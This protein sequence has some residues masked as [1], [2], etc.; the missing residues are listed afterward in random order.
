MKEE[1]LKNVPYYGVDANK[2][3]EKCLGFLA[4]V[5][6]ISTKERERLNYELEKVKEWGIAKVFLFAKELC[7]FSSATTIVSE[8]NSYINYLLEVVEV[9]ACAYDLPFERLYNEYRPYLPTFNLYVTKGRKGEIL[10]KLYEKYG[11]STI[12][13]AEDNKD[14]YYV[15]SKS[16][17]AKFIKESV[18][19]AKE[20]EED[21]E[22]II[23]CLTCREL[24]MLGYYNFSI[25]EVEDISYSLEEKFTEDIIYEKAKELF[26]YKIP[27]TPSFTEIEEIK[28]ILKDTENKLIYQEQVMEILNKICE[29]D[30]SKADHLRREIAKARRCS[31]NEVEKTLTSKY[32]D[33]GQE[34]FDYIFKVGRYSVSKGYVLANL[35]VL[36]EY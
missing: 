11:K 21:Y 15:S 8:N 34:L 23:S 17:E 19:I 12:V 32:G 7:L 33:K 16:F 25:I 14:E 6:Q 3:L 35:H 4:D 26:S 10:K 36:I 13:R 29:F 28:E 27:D 24:D 22:E 20:G 5:H 18:I 31:L 9:N 2:E 1:I 30:M